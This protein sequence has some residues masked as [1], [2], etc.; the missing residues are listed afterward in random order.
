MFVSGAS[1]NGLWK[2]IIVLVSLV[3]TSWF[4]VVHCLPGGGNLEMVLILLFFG[5]IIFVAITFDLFLFG[6]GDADLQISFLEMYE[7]LV[8]DLEEMW[9]AR[10]TCP[11]EGY[12]FYSALDMPLLTELRQKNLFNLAIESES[13]LNKINFVF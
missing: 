9:R 4:L 10:N 11:Q 12:V 7:Q 2:N 1:L 5:S 8:V 3:V 6:D 13:A